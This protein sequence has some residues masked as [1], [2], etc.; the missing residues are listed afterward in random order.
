MKTVTLTRQLSGLMPNGQ[1]W[2]PAG[3]TVDLPDQK[4]ADIVAFG[5][6]KYGSA[7]V[8]K[9]KPTKAAAK[10]SAPRKSAAKKSAPRKP[11]AVDPVEPPEDAP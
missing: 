1:P 7:K 4:A 2:P 11:P 5:W 8:R 6:A 3:E 9:A 10:R